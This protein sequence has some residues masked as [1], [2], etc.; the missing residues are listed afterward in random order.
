MFCSKGVAFSY[1]NS[2]Q[3]TSHLCARASRSESRSRARGNNYILEL[4][5]HVRKLLAVFFIFE[6]LISSR[7]L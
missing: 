4:L 3:V 1:Y 5:V 2:Y 7:D 6:R